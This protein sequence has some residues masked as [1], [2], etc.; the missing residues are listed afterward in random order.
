MPDFQENPAHPLFPP[1]DDDDDSPAALISE[2]CVQR[3]ELGKKVTCPRMFRG[4]ELM[5]LT[6]LAALYGGGE[7]ELIGR[8]NNRITSRRRYTIPGANKPM[9]EGSVQEAEK[10]VTQSQVINPMQ[11]MIGTGDGGIMGL[12]MMMMQQMMQAQAQAAQNQTQMFLAMMTNTQQQSSEEKAQARAELQA[13]IER[14]RQSAERT[15]A[16]MR[17]MMQSRPGS[18]GEEFSKGIEFMR[19]FAMQQIQSA[20][21]A[22]GTGGESELERLLGT[23]LELVQGYMAFKQQTPN[24]AQ[25]VEGAVTG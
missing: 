10:P 17:E 12:I 14:E 3:V 9:Y 15:M 18:S 7:Y 23:G 24:V 16:M 5:S 6:D 4:E 21:E 25:T 22:A 1:D 2:I 8:H 19:S 11:A 13:N 20:K